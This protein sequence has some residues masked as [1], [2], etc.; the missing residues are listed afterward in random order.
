MKNI[1]NFKSLYQDAPI[2]LKKVILNQWK[3]PQNP[4]WHPEGNTLKHIIYV[5]QR[6]I[7]NHPDDPDMIMAAFF[8]DLGKFDTLDTNPKTG[9]PTA[10]GHELVSADLVKQY[11][12]WISSYGADPEK[13]YYIVKNH[14]KI[15][16]RTWDQMKPIKK[17]PIIGD[18][19]FNKLQNF[20]SLDIGG[21]F[22]QETIK[23]ILKEKWSNKYK[24]TI[25]CNN[26]KGFSQKAHCA[27]RKKR[28]SGE[29]TKSKSPFKKK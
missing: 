13:V 12:D 7:T 25:N 6:A 15:K 8:H 22:I 9:H 19:S 4:E 1:L 28:Q 16:P 21:K 27:A 11:S 14:M 29:S 17:D 26:P 3:A 20:T 24:R 10:Y 5:V 23:R 2:E 18:P